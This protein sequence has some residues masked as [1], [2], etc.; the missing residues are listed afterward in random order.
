M[1]A[2]EP[3]RNLPRKVSEGVAGG[4]YMKSY[5]TF[6]KDSVLRRLQVQKELLVQPKEEGRQRRLSGSA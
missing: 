2:P 4:V 5:Q 6:Q 3:G 1:D